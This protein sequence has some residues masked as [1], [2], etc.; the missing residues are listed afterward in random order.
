MTTTRARQIVLARSKGK[1]ELSD[2]RLEKTAIPT[3][4]EGLN[5]GNL[6][7]REAA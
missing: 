1:P 2:F 5:F 7:V 6:I 4:L 3:M